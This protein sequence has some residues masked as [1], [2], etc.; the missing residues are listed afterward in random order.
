MLSIAPMMDY[1]DRHY[2]Y[3]MRLLC[4]RVLLYT[5]M[6]TAMALAH[7]D[8]E[9]LLA[10]DKAEHPLV[11]QLG[12]SDPLLLAKA[13]RIAAEYGYDAVNL[14]VGCPSPRVQEGRFGACLMAEPDLVVECIQA[15]QEASTLPVTVKTR[16][17]IGRAEVAELLY[18]LIEKLAA[19]KVNTFVIHARN[20]WLE[21]LSPKENRTVPPLNYDAV[22]QLQRDFPELSFVLNG[23]VQNLEDIVRLAPQFSGVMIGRAAYHDPYLIAKAERILYPTDIPLPNRSEVVRHYYHY[24]SEQLANG[25]RLYPLLKPLLGLFLGEPKGRLWRRL[26]SGVGQDNPKI[27]LQALEEVMSS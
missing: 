6:V 1:T 4:P 13:T 16:L 15:M 18:P 26:L 12:G 10:F 25:S 20:A 17:G 8:V 23:G 11:L 2:R 24:A 21:G 3:L 19:A 27:I 14:N 7:G 9:R 22:Y 5:E